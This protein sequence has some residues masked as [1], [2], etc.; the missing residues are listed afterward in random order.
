MVRHEIEDQAEIMALQR[1]AQA[2][3]ASLAAEFGIESTM[4]DDIVAM[5]RP[6]ARLHQ[7]RGVEMGDAERSEVRYD[8]GGLVEVETGGEL[9]AIC[10]ERNDRRHD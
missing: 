8:L 3:E 4:V 1:R 6:S 10:G 9:Q 2:G 5:G 7:R